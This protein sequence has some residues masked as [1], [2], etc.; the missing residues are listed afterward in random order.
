MLRANLLLCGTWL[1]EWCTVQGVSTLRILRYKQTPFG[2]NFDVKTR[3]NLQGICSK[4]QPS[5]VTLNRQPWRHTD[6]IMFENS[7]LVDRYDASYI[8]NMAV[9]W[10][11]RD[12][13]LRW[14]CQVHS[15]LERERCSE[16]W[17]ALWQV[18]LQINK[19]KK[20]FPTLKRKHKV[21]WNTLAAFEWLQISSWST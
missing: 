20:T 6:S 13:Y 9:N 3:N 1:V 14:D 4:C 7:Q 11:K 2:N 12:T 19:N 17:L 21:Q 18:L 8:L 5:A 16:G 10:S 15:V